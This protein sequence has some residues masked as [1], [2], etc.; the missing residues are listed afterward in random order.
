MQIFLVGGAVRDELLGLAIRERDWV[1]VG[2]KAGELEKQGYQK[3]GKDFPVFLHPQSKE[4]YALARTERKTGRGYHGFDFHTNSEVT[5]EEDLRR[6]DLT[7]NAI[8]QDP[9]GRLIDPYGG[10]TD[11]D[12]RVLRHVS[13]AFREDPVRVLRVARFAARFHELGFTVAASTLELMK[14]MASS[15]EVGSLVPERVWTETQRA[16]GE[17]HPE[18]FFQVLRDCGALAVIFP[19]VDALF[20][21][22]QP[23]QWHPE[24]DTGV[25]ILLAL[26][27]AAVLQIS[28][29]ARF[30]VL[31]HDLGKATTQKSEL[32]RHRG[33]EQRSIKLV[34]QL[35]DRLNVPNRYRDLA[36]HVAQYHTHCHMA[37]E[38]RPDTILKMLDAVDAF[39]R[40]ERFE[41][42]LAAAQ[43][44][45]QGRKG[46]QDNAYPQADLLRSARNAAAKVNAASIAA[47]ANGQLE[48]K[49]LGK[50]INEARVIA[51]KNAKGVGPR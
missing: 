34:N 33:H 39:R 43:A 46:C 24:I 21:V 3:V 48:G 12:D 22:P 18:I 4:E 19:E 16:L 44:D 25:H 49:A 13:E 38:L 5:L 37:M 41:D 9:D 32:P 23:E 20:G 8:A 7:I 40:P 51:I 50:A 30:A 35:C 47:A 31:V 36:I 6:R 15:G 2:A 14:E 27:Q 45:S 29:E 26:R 17:D 28:T 42:F 1:V 11:I 10:Q